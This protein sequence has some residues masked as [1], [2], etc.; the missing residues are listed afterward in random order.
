MATFLKH[1]FDLS[2]QLR[3]KK[4]LTYEN[5]VKLIQVFPKLPRMKKCNPNKQY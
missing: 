5:T 1:P 2:L 4:L 3:G